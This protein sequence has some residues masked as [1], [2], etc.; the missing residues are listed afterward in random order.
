MIAFGFSVCI[1]SLGA[2]WWFFGVFADRVVALCGGMAVCCV[3]V[4]MG[5]SRRRAMYEEY[6][7]QGW[8]DDFIRYCDAGLSRQQAAVRVLI[9]DITPTVLFHAL[10]TRAH[11]VTIDVGIFDDNVQDSTSL[12]RRL[13]RSLI[14]IVVRPTSQ[15]SIYVLPVRMTLLTLT[16]ML[17]T[18]SSVSVVTSVAIARDVVTL[19]TASVLLAIATYSTGAVMLAYQLRLIREAKAILG[20]I[21]RSSD[22]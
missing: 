22:D 21:R 20:G 3:L 18:V 5:E 15:R 19:A 16:S 9:I 13:V 14:I 7:C 6:V 12:L 10:S 1:V 2:T 17:F 4:G 8:D 11:Y